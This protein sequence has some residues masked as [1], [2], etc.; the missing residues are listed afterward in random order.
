MQYNKPPTEIVSTA[1]PKKQLKTVFDSIT[2]NKGNNN[3]CL[4]R[5]IAVGRLDVTTQG[6]LIL[7]SSPALAN[8]LESPSNGFDRVYLARVFGEVRTS[9]R[10][11]SFTTADRH[12]IRYKRRDSEP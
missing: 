5:L 12:A 1:S 11:T 4:P 2:K 3:L 6:L 8:H 10:N 7:T 9:P